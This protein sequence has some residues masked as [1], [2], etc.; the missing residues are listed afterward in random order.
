MSA[1]HAPEIPNI[2]SI[3]AEANPDSSFWQTILRYENIVFTAVSVIFVTAV[4]YIGTRPHKLIPERLQNFLEFLYTG[5]MDFFE[6]IFESKERARKYFPFLSGLFIFILCN[7][8]MGLIPLFKSTNSAYTSTLPLALIVF[9]YVQWTAV[10][11]LGLI[12]YML[13]LAGDPKEPVQIILA[14]ILFVLHIIG[15]IA[16]PI[17]LS[18]RL[19]GNIMAEDTLLGVFAGF[20]VAGMVALVAFVNPDTASAW[21]GFPV[22]LP[23]YFLSMIGGLVQAFVFT[24]LAAIYLS[25]VLPHQEGH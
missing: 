22:H 7:N 17:T 4:V 14:P 19:F 13:H 21:V 12:G 16:R 11:E 18:L 2:I 10:T 25:L 3:I 24:L 1:G 15:E 5:L 6:G 9:V 23:F 20:G 8:Y